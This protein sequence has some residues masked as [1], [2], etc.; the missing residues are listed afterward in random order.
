MNLK[1]KKPEN[2]EPDYSE[3]GTGHYLTPS[4]QSY[5]GIL[6]SFDEQDLRN[7]RQ[8]RFVAPRTSPLIYL[9]FN[10]QPKTNN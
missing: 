5:T 8:S 9:T 1:T 7:M 10:T 6:A 4:G 2:V 3:P